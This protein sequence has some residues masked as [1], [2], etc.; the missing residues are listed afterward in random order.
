MEETHL[1]GIFGATLAATGE[2]QPVFVSEMRTEFGGIKNADFANFFAALVLGLAELISRKS[3][4][5]ICT[6]QMIPASSL[7]YAD[8]DNR[9]VS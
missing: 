9:D 3:F 4:P 7:A 6:A 1:I 5:T 2:L 8:A